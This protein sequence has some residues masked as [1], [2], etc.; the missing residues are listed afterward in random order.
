MGRQLRSI[1]WSK[2][3]SY[4]DIVG[5]ISDKYMK[6]EE[7]VIIVIR[8]ISNNLAIHSS[9]SLATWRQAVKIQDIEQLDA[10]L[11]QQT[12]ELVNR[13]VHKKDKRV[14]RNDNDNE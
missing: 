13:W 12:L 7:I 9:R 4:N 10:S 14:L 1:P 6:D 8:R 3:D 2:P 5:S 11:Q